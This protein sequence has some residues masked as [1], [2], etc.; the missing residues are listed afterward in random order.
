MN[1]ETES[2]KTKRHYFAMR[3]VDKH[4]IG[5]CLTSKG[6]IKQGTTLRMTDDTGF[7]SEETVN[8]KWQSCQPHE[9]TKEEK[10]KAM[11]EMECWIVD[12]HLRECPNHK[13]D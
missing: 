13:N 12:N 1:K 5:Y 8:R 6:L 9:T 11:E 4:V 3:C 2:N 7:L 10:E